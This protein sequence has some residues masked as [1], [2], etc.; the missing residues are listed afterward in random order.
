MSYKLT[1][2][3]KKT[4]LHAIISGQNTKENVRQYLEEVLLK[5]EEKNCFRVLIEERLEG[6]RLKTFDVF[7]IVSEGS[8]HAFSKFHSIVYVDI[9]AGGDLM[10]F[11]D[12]V[13][14]NRAIPVSV[15]STAGEAEEWLLSR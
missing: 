14:V 11:A 10:H 4:C 5:C 9:N 7:R 3:E 2:H 6:P 15:F 13:A 1:I 8:R 12:T